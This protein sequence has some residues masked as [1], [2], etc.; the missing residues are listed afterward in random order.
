MQAKRELPPS[1]GSAFSVAAAR[2][3]GIGRSRLRS[4]DLERP[5]RGVRLRGGQPTRAQDR[6]EA[7][8]ERERVLIEGLHQRL[9]PGQFFS[10]RSAA[11]IW[12]V[13]LP[14][15]DRPEIHVSVVAPV[16]APRILNVIGHR[17]ELERS[18]PVIR[19]GL[20]VTSAAATWAALGTLSL[21]DLVAAGDALVRRHRPGYGRSRVGAAP[22]TTREELAEM[23]ALGRWRNQSRL[24]Q[25]LELIREDSWSPRESRVRVELVLAGL[26][27]P[28][29]NIDVHDRHGRF[30]ACVDMS[31]PKYKVAVEY[32]GGHHSATYAEDIERIERL[33]AEGWIVIQVSKALAA[34][35]GELVRRVETA[36]R[37]RGWVG[38]A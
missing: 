1:L 16:R 2:D 25:A 38:A 21:L 28:A 23:V 3:L 7:A 26:P 22:L 15:R 31:Y 36:L 33:R 12:E 17:L 19:A 27:E 11:L 8:R 4:S 20:P 32:Q 6:F 34:R 30:L 24:G 18:R 13:P 14:H 29:L 10:H 37:R 9:V 35:P 5:Y